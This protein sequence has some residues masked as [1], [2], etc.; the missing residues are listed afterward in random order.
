ML[1][2]LGTFKIHFIGS[3]GRWLGLGQDHSSGSE[4]GGKYVLTSEASQDGCA[5]T[6]LWDIEESSDSLT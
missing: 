2:R 6:R 4:S 3:G 5:N 1:L